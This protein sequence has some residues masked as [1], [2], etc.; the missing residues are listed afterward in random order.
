MEK[1]TGAQALMKSLLREGVDTIF[2]YPGGAIMPVYD[3]LYDYKDSVRHVLVRHEQG[4][5]HAAEGYSRLAGKP[6]VCMVT[7]GPGATNLVTGIADAMC[8]SIPIV[9]ITGQVTGEALGTDA[10]QEAPIIG[11]VTPVTKWCYQIT[12]A[13]E[14]P[15]IVA[16]AF[17]IATSGRKGPVLIDITKDAQFELCEYDDSIQTVM[18]KSKHDPYYQKKLKRAAALLNNAK[19]PYVLFGHGI[20]LSKAESELAQFIEKGGFPAASTLLGLSSLP[21]SHQLYVGMLG[22][23]GNYGP[24]KLTNKADVIL[25]IGMRFDD[26][27]TGKISAYAPQAK[28]IHVDIDYAELDK[29]IPAEVAIHADAKEFLAQLTPFI[30]SKN[31]SA[32]IGRFRK[33]DEEERKVVA[34][35]E[36][37]PKSG[38][39]RMAE[40]VR[41]VSEKTKG[42]AVIVADVGQHQMVAARYYG[43]ET[44][45]SYIT[46][47]GLGTMGF[48]L[49]ASVGAK[50][51][52]PSREV[53]AII[54][55]GSFQMTLQELGTIMQEKLS[56]KIIILNNRHL[57]MVRQWQEMFFEERY[58]FVHMEN[59]N[60]NKIADAYSIP[61][62]L[63]QDRRTL[64]P[65][66][67]RMLSAKGSYLLDVMVRRDENVFPMIASG[68][69]VDEIRLT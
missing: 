69:G 18:L 31:H 6:G 63:V 57:G 40:V 26:R 52:G 10:F 47:G 44:P 53:I 64:S 68:A 2:G 15:H 60:F 28:I 48:A 30:K 50:I 49:P 9:C 56:I 59:P 19:R 5:A 39:I 36:L 32:W 34:D 20:A 58:S 16:K 38:E 43:F 11:I 42:R 62:E 54:G 55:D 37:Y 17:H 13:A 46:S 45:D 67:E 66:L 21:K 12:N 41:L 14:I 4:A 7:S 22:M 61:N 1:I 65:A 51:A 35:A 27:V 29:V 25:A 23:H 3:A 8:D 33:Y 24:N